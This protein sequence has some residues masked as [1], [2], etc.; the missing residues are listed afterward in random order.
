MS[1]KQSHEMGAGQLNTGTRLAF[2]LFLARAYPDGLGANGLALISFGF[3]IAKFFSTA[4][5]NGDTQH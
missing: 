2:V 4:R 5:E 1:D 3:T